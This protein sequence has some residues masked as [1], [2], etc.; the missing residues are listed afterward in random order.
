MN[1]LR[2]C[3]L[4]QFVGFGQVDMMPRA[5]C[6]VVDPPMHSGLLQNSLEIRNVAEGL[7]Y[8]TEECHQRHSVEV[9]NK[10]EGL[11]KGGA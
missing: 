11:E 6:L 7:K 8:L 9:S 3:E 2:S 4:S 10:A 1:A 5:G